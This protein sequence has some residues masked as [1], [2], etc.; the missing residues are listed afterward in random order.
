LDLNK[1]VVLLE[2]RRTAILFFDDSGSKG[3]GIN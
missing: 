1:T 3:E 2:T